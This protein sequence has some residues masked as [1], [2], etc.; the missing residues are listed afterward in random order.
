MSAF[1]L[2][3]IFQVNPDAPTG[4][5]WQAH[6]DVARLAD[7]LGLDYVFFA[8]RH[9]MPHY[10]AST[11][12]LLL[13]ALAATTTRVRL[14]TMAWTLALHHPVFL[15]EKISALDHLSGGR[16]EVGLGLGH[17]PQEIAAIGL[18]AEH[19]QALFLEALLMMRQLWLGKPYTYDG[20]LYH[21]RDVLVD[22]PLQKPHPPLWYAGNDPAAA[23]WAKRNGLSLAIG[24][25]P[26]EALRAPAE[27]FAGADG[28]LAV[29][30]H[31]YIAASDDAAREE[32]VNDLMRV[33]AEL[34]ANPRGIPNAPTTPPSRAEA[35]RQHADLLAKQVII[36]GGPETVAA[37]I[38]RTMFALGAD[39]FLA[40]IHL[41][42]V[43]D[44]RLRATLTRYAEDVI[45]RV[46][47][48]LAAS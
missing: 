14:G 32:I 4:P 43:E 30:R 37:E 15:A 26:D 19:R 29:M 21:V 27:A 45:P 18:P 23:G 17:R 13:A 8:E 24:F 44:A 6:L 5:T 35:E 28:R 40:N 3:D 39:V 33:G 10:R 48:I 25:Q 38:A 46:R 11:P 12:G 16:L 36:A 42:G 31:L 47:D 41:T 22:P 1:G 20:A 9:F 34:A 2:F 7:R